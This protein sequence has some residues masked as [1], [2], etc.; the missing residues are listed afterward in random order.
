[1]GTL[2]GPPRQHLLAPQGDG[3]SLEFS[4]CNN[5]KQRVT[6]GAVRISDIQESPA[7]APNP[8]ASPDQDALPRPVEPSALVRSLEKVQQRCAALAEAAARH[9]AARLVQ[10][11]RRSVNSK[12]VNRHPSACAL[13]EVKPHNL[14]RSEELTEPNSWSPVGITK[15]R[16]RKTRDLQAFELPNTFVL[17]GRDHDHGRLTVL[18]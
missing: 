8:V 5:A 13:N 16:S 4:A 2:D 15:K 11:E 1:M 12:S 7:V 6:A 3:S 14:D 18:G 17:V 10:H 9:R